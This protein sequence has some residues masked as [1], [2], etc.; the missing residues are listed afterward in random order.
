MAFCLLLLSRPV[1]SRYTMLPPL[2]PL[3]AVSVAVAVAVTTVLFAA[4]L[5]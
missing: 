3:L 2:L 4:A 5:S 1:T